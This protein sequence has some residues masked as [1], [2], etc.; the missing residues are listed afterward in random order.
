MFDDKLQRV[1]EILNE[2]REEIKASIFGE[3]N[4]EGILTAHYEDYRRCIEL[5]KKALN[6]LFA[7][8]K[9]F[10]KSTDDKIKQSVSD[11]E[12][13][14]SESLKSCSKALYKFTDS[15]R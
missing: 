3:P 7:V 15:N 13:K 1:D 10:W 14:C 8:D 2:L 9:A 4:P 6:K 5:N 11:A 12:S